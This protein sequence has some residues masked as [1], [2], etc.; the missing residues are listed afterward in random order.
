MDYLNKIKSY[1]ISNKNNIR[2]LLILVISSFSFFVANFLARNNLQNSDYLIFSY[3]LS[4]ISIINSYS[5]T[6]ADALILKYCNVNN[7]KIEIPK[8]LLFILLFNSILSGIIFIILNGNIF[9]ITLEVFDLILINITCSLGLF[10]SQSFR[11]LRKAFIGQLVTNFWRLILIFPLFLVFGNFTEVENLFRYIFVSYL[12]FL[13]FLFRGINFSIIILTKKDYLNMSKDW[14]AF[15]FSLFFLQLL[16]HGD[17]IL[18][19]LNLFQDL[20]YSDYYYFTFIGLIPINLFSTLIS[21]V[22]GPIIND[23]KKDFDY[24]IRV[25]KNIFIIGSLGCFIF[26]LILFLNKDFVGINISDFAPYI[27]LSCIGVIRVSYGVLSIY[28]NLKLKHFK[29]HL[30][31]VYSFLGSLLIVFSSIFVG[32]NN[33]L[34]LILILVLSVFSLR[35]LIFYLN[36][37]KCFDEE[38]N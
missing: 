36:I 27:L 24:F 12:I 4:L 26:H 32:E 33:G 25:Q 19:D 2:G 38:N 11:I 37:K 22:L 31:N 15:S 10:M 21:Y 23:K 3:Y 7:D 1:T 13:F 6:G 35:S 16:F 8:Q 34:I 14:I 9:N 5:L 17:K 29:I 28:V 20:L 18:V 30:I